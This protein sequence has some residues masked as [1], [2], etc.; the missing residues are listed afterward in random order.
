MMKKTISKTTGSNRILDLYDKY[1]SA[2]LCKEI[3]LDL[4]KG[5]YEFSYDE[6]KLLV[7]VDPLFVL[8]YIPYSS[9]FIKVW[10]DVKGFVNRDTFPEKFYRDPDLVYYIIS[11]TDSFSS[12]MIPYITE[13]MLFDYA[14]EHTNEDLFKLCRHVGGFD[15]ECEFLYKRKYENFFTNENI[16]TRLRAVDPKKVRYSWETKLVESEDKYE[17]RHKKQAELEERIKSDVLKKTDFSCG[18]PLISNKTEITKTKKHELVTIK[19]DKKKVIVHYISDLHLNHK[20]YDKAKTGKTIGE[21]TLEEIELSVSQIVKS[22]KHRNNYD[23]EKVILLGGDVTEDFEIAKA[24]Y[25][26]LSKKMDYS[27]KIITVLGNH[28]LWD[29][30]AQGIKKHNLKSIVSKYTK[31]IGDI[32]CT[33]LLEN[34]I[35]ACVKGRPIQISEEMLYDESISIYLK[36]I[37]SKAEVIVFGAIGFSGNNEHFNSE[38]GIYRATISGR[39]KE[40]ELSTRCEKAYLRSINLIGT[41]RFICLTHMPKAD[42]SDNV[43]LPNCIYINGHTHKNYYTLEGSKIILA[44]NQIGYKGANYS[45]KYFALSNNYDRFEYLPD[46]IHE[47]HPSEYIE[48]AELKGLRYRYKRSDP[49]KMYVLKK[50]GFYMFA[51]ESK[52]SI[53]ILHGGKKE[54]LSNRNLQ[55]YFDNM[56]ILAE[57]LLQSFKGY[58]DRI[59]EISNSIK[60]LGGDGRIHG[61]IVDIDFYNHMYLNPFDG[62]L[63]AYCAEDMMSRISYPTL[64]LLID[65]NP[66]HSPVLQ[67]MKKL[68]STKNVENNL[69]LKS[70]GKSQKGGT[71]TD[72]TFIYSISNKTK[73]IQTLFD[74]NIIQVW[75]DKLINSS[76]KHLVE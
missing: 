58:V 6:L 64:N 2:L 9:N 41:N 15:P 21:T 37:L 1:H 28:E 73:K 36:R 32:P 46:G 42:W 22:I 7:K 75:D 55:Y 53:C 45:L 63:T 11:H 25:Y 39:K 65:N 66:S 20:I 31:M 49:S 18:A 61:C 60:D 43:Y 56:D 30:D 8:N 13:Q 62:T 71:Y 40:Q 59:H 35:F 29:G 5:D 38:N 47:I 23:Y 69:A 67:N 54:K 4:L 33:F 70:K 10:V 44:D 27:C 72:G 14:E 34:S 3:A 24:F 48:F 52:S 50:S 76:K 26:L 17:L 16:K 19:D 74:A 68:I 12:K 57:Q 51:T